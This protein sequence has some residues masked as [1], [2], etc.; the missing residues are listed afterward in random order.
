MRVPQRERFEHRVRA[1]VPW[2]AQ[3]CVRCKATVKAETMYRIRAHAKPGSHREYLC[4]Q[5]APTRN[6]ALFYWTAEEAAS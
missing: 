6:R 3:H 5:C 1:V 4:T 2:F